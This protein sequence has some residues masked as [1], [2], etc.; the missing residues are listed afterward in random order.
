MKQITDELSD[1]LK[2]QVTTICT[3]LTVR[4]RDGGAFHFTDHDRRLYVDETPY[5]P[6]HAFSR[7]SIQ[8]S[9][10]LDV[11]QMEIKGILNS[12]AISRVDV[13]AGLFD[14]AEVEVFVVNYEDPQA[15][16]LMLRKGWIGE[17]TLS[18]DG[19]FEAEIRGLTQ[20]FAYRIGEAYSPECRAD[21]GDQRCKVPLNPDEWQ[22]NR[23]YREG[24]AVLIPI[25][26]A[27][28]FT[29]LTGNNLGF[30]D[31]TV[32]QAVSAPEGWTGYGSPGWGWAIRSGTWDD[33]T[34]KIG[35]RFVSATSL[36]GEP[37]ECGMYQ[38]FSLI[39]AG[40]DPADIDTGLCRAVLSVWVSCLSNVAKARVRLHAI[41]ENGFATVIWDTGQKQYAEDKWFQEKKRDILIP[42]GTRK[43]RIDLWSWKK[44][45]HV[46]G[47][48]FDGVQLSVNSPEGSLGSASQYGQVVFRCLVGGTS[49]S[50][51]PAFN[52]IIG[53]EQVEGTVTWVAGQTWKTLSEVDTTISAFAFRPLYVFED[54]GYYDGGLLVWETG[55]NAGRAQ[56]IKTW[57]GGV[58]TLFQRP[59]WAPEPGDRIVLHPGCDKRRGTC[60]DKFANILNFRGEPDVPGQDE[61]Y[62]TPNSSAG[63]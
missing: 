31:G 60:I 20:V 45:N 9:L 22:P 30:E 54:D 15:G 48:A 21:L 49:G 51:T 57:A 62:K 16:K 29:N 58:V 32:N 19:T 10:D 59:F 4:R 53:E 2:A 33:Q 24:D 46:N 55:R 50:T 52:N 5:T 61:Y 28:G 1:H 6:W 44:K 63:D 37:Y 14:F 42:A 47:A 25:D 13:A 35:S 38:D 40:L 3:C 34:A 41:D 18:E 7:T 43:L 11:D 23:V 12:R 8:T 36:S 27:F 39:S 56:E 26:E 17:I